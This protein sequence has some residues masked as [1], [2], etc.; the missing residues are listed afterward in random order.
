MSFSGTITDYIVEFYHSK[1]VYNLLLAVIHIIKQR[2][3]L[4]LMYGMYCEFLFRKSHV[5]DNCN[6]DVSVNGVELPETYDDLYFS[7]DDLVIR[8]GGKFA[9]EKLPDD[10]IGAR[11][12]GVVVG[13]DFMIIG[14][15]G[16]EKKARLAL[17]INDCCIIYDYYAKDLRVRHI[18]AILMCSNGRDIFVST[19][20][21]AKY[22][23][24]WRIGTD[25]LDF[26]KR[27]KT[28]FA[29]YTAML[30]FGGIVYCGTDFSSRRNYI[31]IFSC[32]GKKIFFPEPAST[33]MC[34]HLY[35]E[36]TFI[37]AISKEMNQFGGKQAVS[38]FDA[39][40]NKFVYC[41][42]L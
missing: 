4:E 23:D 20:D 11:C 39:V 14:E 33:M 41:D 17:L 29:G 36:N 25:G 18:H 12:E 5:S 26:I 35:T 34:I 28:R 9:V 32:K 42:Y 16:Y 40:N 1:K 19:G 27:L 22:L 2:R 8:Y 37:I 7:R 38:V 21:S 24:L 6:A 10:F 31:E 30:E 13:K 3:V 15:Y